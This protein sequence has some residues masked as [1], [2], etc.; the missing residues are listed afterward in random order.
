[1][2]LSNY[3]S[4]WLLKGSAC[5]VDPFCHLHFAF[6]V[7]VCHIVLSVPGSLVVSRPLD[8][9]VCDVFSCFCHFTIWCPGSGVVFSWIDSWYLSNFLLC[10]IKTTETH[11][12]L[13]INAAYQR[14]CYKISGEY[15][16]WI[17][18]MQHLKF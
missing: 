7:C 1:M 10:N 6:C 9:L 12:S 14:L 11:N 5:F 3:F 15:N 17:C 18:Y 8:F 2:I 13:R 4:C 16:S